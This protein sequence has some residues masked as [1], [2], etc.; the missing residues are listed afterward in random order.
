MEHTELRTIWDQN[1]LTLSPKEFDR[2]GKI[3][4]RHG[5]KVTAI[6]SP[7]FKSPRDGVARGVAGDFQS[8]LSLSQQLSNRDYAL[9]AHVTLLW[10]STEQMIRRSSMSL[11]RPLAGP[12]T[13][14]HHHNSL[15]RGQI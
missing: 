12:K 8:R 15:R 5:L 3:V 2:V 1:I 10:P 13:D 9:D 4:D 7:I 6:A 14:D 11:G